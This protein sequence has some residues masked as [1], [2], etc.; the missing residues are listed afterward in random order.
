[1]YPYCTTEKFKTDISQ[2]CEN[3]PL[4]IKIPKGIEEQII[5]QAKEF[6]STDP[7][8]ITEYIQ[9][10]IK[11]A[12][13]SMTEMFYESK[14]AGVPRDAIPKISEAYIWNKERIKALNQF[15]RDIENPNPTLTI[16][17]NILMWLQETKCINGKPFIEKYN[18]KIKWL[19]NKQLAR[20]LLTHDKIK[21]GLTDAEVERQTP[22]LFFY[23]K[24]SKQL[25]LANNKPAPSLDSDKL[26]DFLATL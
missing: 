10:E 17:A 11:K 14:K 2:L 25:I 5:F 12:Q 1:M 19:Q 13:N 8:S 22:N 21:N 23:Y 4:A 16:P 18:G 9:S 26:R 20:E 7:D 15:K 24:D 3:C 6:Y